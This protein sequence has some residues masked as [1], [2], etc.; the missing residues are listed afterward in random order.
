[1]IEKRDGLYIWRLRGGRPRA[2]G[3]KFLQKVSRQ[4]LVQC[5]LMSLL[6]KPQHQSGKLSNHQLDSASR[7]DSA[8]EAAAAEKCNQSQRSRK[9]INQE[10]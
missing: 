1:M 5:G 10:S 3:A 7:K 6:T 2:A 4:L 8:P 9:A